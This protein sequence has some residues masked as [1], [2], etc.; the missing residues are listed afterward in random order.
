MFDGSDV[1]VKSAGRADMRTHTIG[2]GRVLREPGITAK[3][4]ASKGTTTQICVGRAGGSD[5]T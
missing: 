1:H 3:L 5:P 2:V 4:G